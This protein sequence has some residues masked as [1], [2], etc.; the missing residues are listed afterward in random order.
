[1]SKVMQLDIVSAEAKLFSGQVKSVHVTGKMGELGIH[2]G[3]TQLLTVLKP[4]HIGIHLDT[5]KRDVFYVSGGFLEVQPGQ[6]TILADTAIRAADLDEV[7]AHAAIEQANKV[8]ADKKSGQD[9]SYALT[10]LAQAAAQ[11]RAISLLKGKLKY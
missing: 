3:H 4:G 9:Y 6:V 5:G 7:A 2:P 10:E 8:L 11:L 1:M